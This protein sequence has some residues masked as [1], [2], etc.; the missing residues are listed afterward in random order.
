MKRELSGWL[1]FCEISTH[2]NLGLNWP[3]SG[4]FEARYAKTRDLLSMPKTR[5]GTDPRPR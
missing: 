5:M 2:L 4:P 1:T 3:D